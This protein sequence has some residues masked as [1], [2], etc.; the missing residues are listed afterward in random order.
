MRLCF[1]SESFL[2]DNRNSLLLHM[3]KRIRITP[4]LE[5]WNQTPACLLSALHR[6]LS[7]KLIFHNPAKDV[8]KK[9]RGPCTPGRAF[10]VQKILEGLV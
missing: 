2:Y 4:F 6:T 7:G 9:A 10:A 1:L 3:E 5:R 8:N